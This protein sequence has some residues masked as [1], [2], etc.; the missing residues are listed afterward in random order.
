[1][2]YLQRPCGW[3]LV[4]KNL[5]SILQEVASWSGTTHVNVKAPNFGHEK[6]LFTTSNKNSL[7]SVDSFHLH[8][9][10]TACESL[11]HQFKLY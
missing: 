4:N 7:F 6:K 8:Y 11:T 3:D 9:S 1:M 2:D 10:C 5:S